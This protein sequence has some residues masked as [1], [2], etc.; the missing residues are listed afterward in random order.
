MFE[1][2]ASAVAFVFG[3]LAIGLT[4]LHE[5]NLYRLVGTIILVIFLLFQISCLDMG[6]CD[7]LAYAHALI[8]V[9]LSGYFIY[10]YYQKKNKKKKKEKKNKNKEDKQ[11]DEIKKRKFNFF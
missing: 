5:L 3:I 8:P 1:S 11:V 9:V 6:D 10:M 7:T 2:T 4:F